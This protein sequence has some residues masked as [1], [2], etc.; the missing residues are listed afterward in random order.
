SCP[1]SRWALVE[2]KMM[3][4]VLVASFDFSG[5]S[6]MN[7]HNFLVVRP[8]VDNQFS[9]GHRMPLVMTPL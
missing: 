8:Y 6:P 4:A 7:G 2:I 5:A 9:K 3:L 1:A